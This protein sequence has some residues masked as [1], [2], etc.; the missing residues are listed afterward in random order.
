MGHGRGDGGQRVIVAKLD[1]G[2]GQ[3]IVLIDDGDNAHVQQ[4]LNGV[5]GIEV[6]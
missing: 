6:S 4:L 2:Y 3:R 1:F 5:L